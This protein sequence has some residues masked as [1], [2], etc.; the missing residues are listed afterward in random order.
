[1]DTKQAIAL[2]DDNK[3]ETL[4]ALYLR[5]KYPGLARLIQTGINAEGESIKCR[6]D[7][8]KYVHGLNQCV[9]VACTVSEERQL[10]RK[11]LGGKQT[12]GEDISGKIL[13]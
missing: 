2:I 7:G 5:N 1:M 9:A 4:V 6:V 11:W 8:I 13:P 12:A 3:F 10:K